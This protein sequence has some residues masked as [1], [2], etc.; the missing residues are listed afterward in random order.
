MVGTR[1]EATLPLTVFPLCSATST[2]RRA[3]CDNSLMLISFVNCDTR[4]LVRFLNPLATWTW[5]WVGAPDLAAPCHFVTFLLSADLLW[6]N[7]LQ[8]KPPSRPLQ[9]IA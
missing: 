9:L 1:W 8:E 4:L 2:T 3:S 6:P 7:K 5:K